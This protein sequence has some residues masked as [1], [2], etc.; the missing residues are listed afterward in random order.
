[1][2]SSCCL[3]GLGLAADE[4][5]AIGISARAVAGVVLVVVVAVI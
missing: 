1:M 5:A 3:R 2:Y 4:T